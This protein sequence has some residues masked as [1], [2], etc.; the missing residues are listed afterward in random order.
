MSETE[1]GLICNKSNAIAAIDDVVKLND[2][3]N[4]FHDMP[5]VDDDK[6]AFPICILEEN[7]C[8]GERKEI[9]K[10]WFVCN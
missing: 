4:A 9:T 1:T 2:S 10:A 5:I 7:E 8:E 3:W 6:M